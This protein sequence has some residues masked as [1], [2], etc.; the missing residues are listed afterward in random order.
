MP[1]NGVFPE[2]N[3]GESHSR[4]QEKRLLRRRRNRLKVKFCPKKDD[5][6]RTQYT[7][8]PFI[9]TLRCCWLP[10]ILGKHTKFVAFFVYAIDEIPAI[11]FK[12]GAW[13]TV[14][15][16]KCSLRFSAKKCAFGLNCRYLQ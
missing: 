1:M 2:Q 15:T 14:K 16:R 12:P 6:L 8:F 5:S 9:M 10:G 11:L 13:R 7:S 3:W 4:T